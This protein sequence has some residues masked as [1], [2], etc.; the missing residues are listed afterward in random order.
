MTLKDQL[1]SDIDM[2]LDTSEF[3]VTAT[4]DGSTSVNGIF[5]NDYEAADLGEG[6]VEA[7][8]PTFLYKSSD[9]SN[10]QQGMT[11]VVNGTTYKVREIRPDGTG[12]TLLVLSE[13]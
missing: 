8:V 3:A 1:T 5:D 7:S 10:V 9:I 6:A 4:Y 2:M 13:D 11:L 12:M